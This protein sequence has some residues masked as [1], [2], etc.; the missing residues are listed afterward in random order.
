MKKVIAAPVRLR[1]H[2]LLIDWW[3][4]DDRPPLLLTGAAC[5]VAGEIYDA[6]VPSKVVESRDEDNAPR[7]QVQWHPDRRYTNTGRTRVCDTTTELLDQICF[8]N[9]RLTVGSMDVVKA[10]AGSL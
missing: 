9:E 2:R 8:E 10:V 1:L 7:T 5:Y 3:Q 4:L 6:G